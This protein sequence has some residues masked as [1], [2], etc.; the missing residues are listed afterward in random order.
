LYGVDTDFSLS[1][2]HGTSGYLFGPPGLVPAGFLAETAEHWISTYRGRV[3]L[4]SGSW[5]FYVT[6]GGA[7]ADVSI[8]AT[9]PGVGIA[10]ES[11]TRW[12]W[13][14]GVGVEAARIH[15]FTVK[16]EYIYADFGNSAYF[17]PPPLPGLINRAG[18]VR[19]YDHIFR[20]GLNHKFPGW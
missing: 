8:T 19:A 5:M 16:A 13:A 3:G 14:A 12:G 15:S 6:G 17:N 4:V 1:T 18:G 2:K 20:I 7:T 10:S 11:K 9:E